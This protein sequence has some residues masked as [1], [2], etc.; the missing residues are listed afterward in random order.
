MIGLMNDFVWSNDLVTDDLM[1][2][3]FARSNYFVMENDDHYHV[4]NTFGDYQ[5]SGRE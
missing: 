1:A 4:Y 2:N 5:L 3:D